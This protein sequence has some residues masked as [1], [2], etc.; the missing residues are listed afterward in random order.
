MAQ[1]EYQ[2]PAPDV[3]NAEKEMDLFQRIGSSKSRQVKSL[4]IVFPKNYRN[5]K[6]QQRQ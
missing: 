2:W 6:L 5:C 4:I 3:N 1:H